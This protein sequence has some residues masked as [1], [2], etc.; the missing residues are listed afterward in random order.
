MNKEVRELRM[1]QGP[2]DPRDPVGRHFNLPV[3][4]LKRATVGEMNQR[5]KKKKKRTKTY[6]Y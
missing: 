6:G 1:A 5:K 2:I 4:L 3:T